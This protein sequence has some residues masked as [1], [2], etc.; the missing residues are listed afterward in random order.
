MD[1]CN[2]TVDDI[3]MEKGKVIVSI[4]ENL[5]CDAVVEVTDPVARKIIMEDV[6]GSFLAQVK[7]S[8]NENP[9][10]K[11]ALV[12]PMARPKHVWYT[13]FHEDMCKL[14]TDSIKEM[15]AQNVAK[16]AGPPRMVTGVHHGRCT[17]N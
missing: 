1:V 9:G 12:Q 4:I 14:F 16:I 17:L 2:T 3:K 10:V 5:I 7:K 13:E 6:V 8:A 15:G 11:F